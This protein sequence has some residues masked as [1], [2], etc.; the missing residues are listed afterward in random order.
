MW[1]TNFT[2]STRE[3][4]LAK[5]FVLV[6]LSNNNPTEANG[7]STVGIIPPIYDG[8]YAKNVHFYNFLYQNTLIKPTA[9]NQY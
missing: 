2:H 1:L 9:N 4:V 7:A 6:A 8:F 5:D 3:P